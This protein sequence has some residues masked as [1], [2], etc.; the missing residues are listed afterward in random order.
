MEERVMDARSRWMEAAQGERSTDRSIDDRRSRGP[1]AAALCL[2]AAM[3]LGAG[4]ARAETPQRRLATASARLIPYDFDGTTLAALEELGQLAASPFDVAPTARFLRAAAAA[5]LYV[6]TIAAADADARAALAQALRTSSRELPFE[7]ERGCEDAAQGYHARQA[8]RYRVVVRCAERG[9]EPECRAGLRSI[10]N[11]EGA[12]SSAARLVLVRQAADTMAA[13]RRSGDL[14]GGLAALVAPTCRAPTLPEVARACAA[15]HEA[16]DDRTLAAVAVALQAFADLE[17]FERSDATDDPFIVLTSALAARARQDMGHVGLRLPV[18]MADLRAGDAVP[19]LEGAS[20][21][22]PMELLVVSANHGASIA[23]APAVSIASA[24]PERLDAGTQLAL[25]GSTIVA[26]PFRFRPVVRPVAAVTEALTRL[27]AEATELAESFDGERPAWLD[28]AGRTLGVVIDPNMMVLDFARFV[29]SAHQAGYE[30]IALVGR[31]ADG[32]L[33]AVPIETARLDEA[34]SPSEL[35][36]AVGASGIRLRRAAG[37]TV[38]LER[39]DPGLGPAASRL[40]DSSRPAVTITASQPWITLD[41]LLSVA[42]TLFASR[43]DRPLTCTLAI[44]PQ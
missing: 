37:A 30:Q 22:L 18:T 21:P 41:W 10:A 26:A 17:A 42:D 6:Y 23:M 36:I 8:E 35:L 16:G 11:T 44:L 7:I 19:V 38:E 13:A 31:R 32:S 34:P 29:W 40:L 28:G 9:A 15:S 1:R 24:T 12:A 43:P 3:V 14:A 39:S 25:P 5:E 33:A 4:P 20:A 2:C 27:R